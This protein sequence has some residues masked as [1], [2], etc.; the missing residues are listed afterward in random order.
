MK[1]YTPEQRHANIL[2]SAVNQGFEIDERETFEQVINDAELYLINNDC[3]GYEVECEV[4]S[5]GNHGQRVDFS[6]GMGFDYWCQGEIV[7]FRNHWFDGPET[8]VYHTALAD[9]E[10][11]VVK[12]YYLVGETDYNQ[13]IEY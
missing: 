1:T 9:S 7:D 6:D 10:G 4:K 11:K 8:K 3:E 5:L 12:L 13:P 2:L